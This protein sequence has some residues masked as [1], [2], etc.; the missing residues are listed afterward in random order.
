MSTVE[1]VCV[2][3]LALIYGGSGLVELPRWRRFTGQFVGW[4]FP[5]WWAAFNPAL[6]I[7]AAVMTIVPQT[8][9]YGVALCVL[10]ALGAAFVVLRFKERAMVKAALPVVA[11]TLLCTALLLAQWA[12]SL[13]ELVTLLKSILD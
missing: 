11:L 10:V 8:R 12:S 3:L 6:K 7:A 13:A 9:P 1:I 5:P 2:G 4:G